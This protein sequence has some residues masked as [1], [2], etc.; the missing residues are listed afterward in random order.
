[1]LNLGG[2]YVKENRMGTFGYLMPWC[3][4][5]DEKAAIN[6]GWRPWNMQQGYGLNVNTLTAASALSWGN[7]LAPATSD[8]KKIMEM[9]AWDAVE[10]EQ[11]AVGS[12]TPFVYR[13]MLVTEYV[14]R[15][16]ATTYKSKAALEKALV[17]TARR[18][19]VERAFANY[20]GN[21]GSAFNPSTYSVQQ[22]A[23]RIGGNE[24]SSVTKTPPWLA[25]SGKETVETVPVMQEGKTAILITG[26][27]NRNKSLCVPGGGFATVKIELPKA[28]DEL[29]KE[30][31]YEPL[32]S[33]YLQTDMKPLDPMPDPRRE[34]YRQ[35]QQRR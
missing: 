3:L 2:Y 16:L 29:T 11:F 18:P 21:P 20:W 31:G 35:Q 9:M 25:W 30:L 7:N 33:F 19:L 10:K 12:G 34:A 26:D 13:T 28:W 4:A 8:A 27:A 22:H 24:G 32:K 23:K 15:D 1:M 5:E 14:A 17:E 6:L